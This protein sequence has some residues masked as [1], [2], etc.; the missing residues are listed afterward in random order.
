MNIDNLPNQT[1]GS[2]V[3]IEDSDFEEINIQDVYADQKPLSNS[4]I[5]EQKQQPLDGEMLKEILDLI[6]YKVAD[7]RDII[8]A[9]EAILKKQGEGVEQIANLIRQNEEMRRILNGKYS[10]TTLFLFTTTITVLLI[11]AIVTHFLFNFTLIHPVLAIPFTI[12]GTC[13]SALS[14]WKMK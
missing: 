3:I 12:A 6:K 13:F 8:R 14:F 10:A 9:E 5:Q 7:K 11:F 1:K 2:D 4:G